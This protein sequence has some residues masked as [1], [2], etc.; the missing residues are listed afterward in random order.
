MPIF[1]HDSPYYTPLS[2]PAWHIVTGFL[3]SIYRFLRWCNRSVQFRNSAYRRFLNLEEYCRKSL[4]RG[5]QKTAEE[6]ALKSPSDI[7]TRAFMWTFDSLDEDHELEH[8]F[9]GLPGFRSSRVVTDPLHSLTEEEKLKLDRALIGLLKRT[10]SSDLLPAP[11]KNGRAMICAKAVDP[12]H[13]LNAWRIFDSILSEY[14]YSG[15]LATAIANI[16]RGWGSNVD[17]ANIL[18][19]QFAISMIIAAR[20]P[21]D[22]SWFIL[23]ANE[24][25]IPE[26]VLRDYAT[27]GDSLSLVILIHIIRQQFSHSRKA[28]WSKYN[29]TFVL[30]T[31][32]NFNVKNTSPS[33]Q[34]D[35]CALWNQVVREVLDRDDRVMAF[36]ILGRIRNV[37]LALHE[38]TD[39]SPTLFSTSTDDWDDVL[40]D[41][42]S[43]P[44]CKGSSHRSDST[45]HIHDDDASATI[46]RTAPHGHNN[47][48]FVHSLAS[49]DPPSSSTHTPLRVDE[50][51][52][53]ALPLDSHLSIPASKQ[54]IGQTTTE[55]PIILTTPPRPVTACTT[56]GGVDFSSRTMLRPASGPS[57]PSPPPKSNASAS[58]P[59]DI[60]VWNTA[61]SCTPSG[62]LNVLSSPSPTSVLDDIPP[63][64]LLLFSGRDQI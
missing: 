51:L 20:Q 6:T 49:P 52:A 17:E 43:Y 9:S 1:R 36:R 22:D 4:G 57:G 12:E 38:D 35:F 62:D 10:F 2:L 53:D 58:P 31:A 14:R 39:S 25:S 41:P 28:S 30:A 56:H 61:L 27:H 42:T 34:H 21:Y 64:G 44:V 24:L 59:D 33:L 7:D 40:K 47:T 16:L 37:Y 13:T 26:A 60:A 3:Y 48:T 11:V 19:V 8:F 29:F 18:Y 23:A 32:S 45:P 63:T 15:P 50:T 46:T 5:M 55:S 54:H